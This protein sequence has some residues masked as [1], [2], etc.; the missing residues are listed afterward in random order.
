MIEVLEEKE[1]EEKVL[2]FSEVRNSSVQWWSGGRAVAV[3][4]QCRG[5]AATAQWRCTG[6]A[7]A[8]QGQ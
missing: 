4:V 5:S 7:R 2:I 1:E 3:T 8:A 6:G